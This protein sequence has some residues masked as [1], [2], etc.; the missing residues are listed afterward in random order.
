M[1]LYARAD[2]QGQL[3]ENAAKRY[4]ACYEDGRGG[5]E[6]DKEKAAEILKAG[7]KS[8]VAELLRTL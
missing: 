4:A 5:L 3:N 2:A 6:V 7:R 8:R 1:A